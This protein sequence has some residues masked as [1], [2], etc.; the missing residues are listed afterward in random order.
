MDPATVS[1]LVATLASIWTAYQEY[2]HRKMK[3]AVQAGKS[4]ADALG[5]KPVKK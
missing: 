1:L 3:K 4:M 5:A 2:R